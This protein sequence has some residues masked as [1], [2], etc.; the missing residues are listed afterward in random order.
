MKKILLISGVLFLLICAVGSVSAQAPT[1]ASDFTLTDCNGAVHQLF[2]DL[3]KGD[4]VVLEFVMGCTPCVQGRKALATMESQFEL[5]HP[6]KFHVYT[7]GYSSSVDCSNIQSWMSTNKFTGICFGGDDDVVANYGAEGGMP[8]L[9]VVG[10][11]DHKVLYWKQGFSNKDT[12]AIKT[13]ISQVLQSQS[14]VSSSTNS[15]E[16][17][18][19]YPNPSSLT[20]SM[21]INCL[22]EGVR[23]V[24]LFSAKGTRVLSIFEGRLSTGEQTVDFSTRDL[25][26]GTYYI[27]VTTGKEST[28]IPLT[29][30]H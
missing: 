29:V 22:K 25:T 13:A 20:A 2:A 23:N 12:L 8:T 4:V 30:V 5:S 18:T 6:G 7:F 21:K 3:D 1:V 28:V 9:C 14:S 27:H 24:T 10:G 16:S 19:I 11:Q 15:N 17:L 26:S